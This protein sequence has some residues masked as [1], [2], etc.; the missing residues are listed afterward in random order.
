MSRK[1]EKRMK[2]KKNETQENVKL[3]RAVYKTTL[4][5]LKTFHFSSLARIPHHLALSLQRMLSGLVSLMMMPTTT[6]LNAEKRLICVYEQIFTR[7]HKFYWEIFDF[8]SS[9]RHVWHRFCH[10]MKCVGNFG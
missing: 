5:C 1:R 2:N 10:H 6:L 9:L 7:H 4:F 8:A 3:I